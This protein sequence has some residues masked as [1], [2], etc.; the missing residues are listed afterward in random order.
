MGGNIVGL[1]HNSKEA[2]TSVFVFMLG[3]VV[4]QYNTVVNVMPTKCL[5][6]ENLT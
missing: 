4:I 2:A 6:A 5:Q 1:F 3:S